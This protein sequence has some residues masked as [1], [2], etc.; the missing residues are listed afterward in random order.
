MLLFLGWLKYL[1]FYTDHN[2]AILVP[3]FKGFHV[4]ELD[5]L[6]E[7]NLL[8][9]A[10]IDS[11]FDSSIPKGIVVNQD[12]LENTYVKK[13]RKIYLTINSLQARKVTFPDV[14]DLTL[15]QAVSKLEHYGFVIGNLEYK[16]DIATNKIL[17]FKVNGIAIDIGQELY[18]GTSVDLVV[19]QGLSAE[20]ILIPNLIGY[21]RDE[22]NRI[23]KSMSLNIGLQ[24]FNESVSDS[25]AAVVYRQYPD[26]VD[27]KKINIGSSIDLYFN[28]K[29]KES[30]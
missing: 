11:V 18:Y 21:S 4:L 13:N 28:Y 25:D 1:D 20:K 8:R 26:F 10:V 17:A 9:Y 16:P 2:D 3:S 29:I 27:G 12:P 30:L 7:S 15:R 6:T 5:S 23:V 24:Y 14:F 19:G 22:A